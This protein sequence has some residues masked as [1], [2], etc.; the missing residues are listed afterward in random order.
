MSVTPPRVSAGRLDD[1]EC[2][3]ASLDTLFRLPVVAVDGYTLVYED[4]ALRERFR[5]AAG[6]GLTRFFFATRLAF[7]PPLSPRVEALLQQTVTSA[8]RGVFADR[9]ADRGLDGVKRSGRRHLTVD[10]G[11]RASV[12]AYSAHRDCGDRT[13]PVEGLL[14]VWREDGFTIAGGVHPVGD[15]GL[16]VDVE[17][18]RYEVELQELIA[19]V[20]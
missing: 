1:W 16:G 17:P 3:E 6:E 14:G 4:E 11:H 5:V 9:L 19:D 18:E 20:A 7:D 2:V 13:L 12:T 10:S 8:A 15:A